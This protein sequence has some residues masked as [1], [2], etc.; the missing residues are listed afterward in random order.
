MCLSGD[1]ESAIPLYLHHLE[2]GQY[3]P[4]SLA[5]HEPT[6]TPQNCKRARC[7]NV[8]RQLT[9]QLSPYVRVVLV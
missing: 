1:F 2:H 3:T 5:Q 9:S 6:A 8:I 4:E 7:A